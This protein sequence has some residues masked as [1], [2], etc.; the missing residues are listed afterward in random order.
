MPARDPIS[1]GA[2][3][4]VYANQLSD[5]LRGGKFMRFD[6]TIMHPFIWN[7]QGA[8]AAFPSAIAAQVNQCLI[9]GGVGNTLLELYQTTAQTLNPKMHATKGLLIGGD[10]VDNESVE[11]VPGGNTGVNPLGYIAGTDQGVYIKAT[12]EHTDTSGVDQFVVGFRKQEAYL[13]PTSLLTGGA[14]G[15]T[16][17]F[18]VGFSGS[19]AANL[20]KTMSALNASVTTVTSL[21]M[22]WAD[23]LVHTLE[24]R[25]KGRRASVFIN[26]VPAGN[27]IA[28]DGLG[29]S[30]TSQ[31]IGSAPAFTFD[32]GDF[33]IPFIFHRYD[34]AVPAA[35]YLRTLEVGQLL[36]SGLDN[37][38]R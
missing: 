25:V 33:L 30:I 38:G 21:G 5:G 1:V 34:A 28:K 16:D 20:I 9:A 3:S 15:Y 17:L 36:E 37:L 26:G 23:T 4:R 12:I 18:G 2:N 11:Y 31:F 14:P 29:N 7:A 8:I 32:V 10:L 35:T 19:A 13:V 24:V 6:R 27:R 22:T